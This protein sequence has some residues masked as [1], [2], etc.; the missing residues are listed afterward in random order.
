[1]EKNLINLNASIDY[2][3]LYLRASNFLKRNDINTIWQLVSLTEE[4]LS[5]FPNIEEIFI[6]NIKMHLSEFN[7]HLGMTLEE[8]NK[9]DNIP[10]ISLDEDKMFDESIIK[11]QTYNEQLKELNDNK[12]RKIII[13]SSILKERIKLVEESKIL[14]NEIEKLDTALNEKTLKI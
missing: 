5:K 10:S 4:D 9:K 7:L 8:I 14:D 12:K 2:L 13:L 1:M 11:H 3:K 6:E